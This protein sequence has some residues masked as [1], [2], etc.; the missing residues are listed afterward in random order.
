MSTMEIK[1]LQKSNTFSSLAT[2]GQRLGTWFDRRARKLS[3]KCSKSIT[4]GKS[5]PNRATSYGV[6]DSWEMIYVNKRR[7][8]PR[9]YQQK[10]RLTTSGDEWAPVQ[11]S[12]PH[13]LPVLEAYFTFLLQKQTYARK[14][15][16]T[17]NFFAPFAA[18]LRVLEGRRLFSPQQSV[19]VRKLDI[20]S[21][22]QKCLLLPP[23]LGGNE[24][25]AFFLC[26]HYKKNTKTRPEFEERYRSKCIVH[27]S[28]I[29]YI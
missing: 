4:L 16:A 19:M 29:E 25:S 5:P 13:S 2:G 11:F 26:K 24:T 22:D 8:L 1:T 21:P 9:H 3:M 18:S 20:N 6:K 10:Q 15:V 28:N 7:R 27:L 17:L 12:T 14:L 23:Q